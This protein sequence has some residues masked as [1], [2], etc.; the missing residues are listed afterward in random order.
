MLAMLDRSDL[1]PSWRLQ[2][3]LVFVGAGLLAL[4]AVYL[5]RAEMAYAGAA[6]NFGGARRSDPESAESTFN[7]QAETT[8]TIV[9]ALD[10]KLPDPGAE[11]YPKPS[12]AEQRIADAFEMNASFEFVETPLIG[13]AM[14]IQEKL[15][16][17]VEIQ[18]D[19]RALQ[20]AGIRDDSP[21]TRKIK[22]LPVRTALQLILNEYDLTYL[23][24]EEMILIT[25]QDK[26]ETELIT[27]TYPVGDLIPLMPVQSIS[28]GGREKARSGY[29]TLIEAITT[30]VR[31]DTWQEVGGPGTIVPVSVSHSLVISQTSDV[32]EAVLELLRA[33]RAAKQDSTR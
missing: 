11:Y 9:P 17:D 30:T 22:D 19:N 6:T 18:L 16:G 5:S 20:D 25:S 14:A 3:F 1:K 10:I 31:Q 29:E 27:R 2:L 33:L 13:V 24:R 12:E 21:V 15:G 23:L 26:A 8:K 7:T 4:P 28:G 32:H